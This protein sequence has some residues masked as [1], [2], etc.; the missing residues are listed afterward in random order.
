MSENATGYMLLDNLDPVEDPEEGLPTEGEGSEALEDCSYA[1]DVNNTVKEFAYSFR[2][3]RAVRKEIDHLKI[4]IEDIEEYGVSVDNYDSLVRAYPDFADEGGVLRSMCSPIR[5][6]VY[7]KEFISF[8]KKKLKFAEKDLTWWGM[9]QSR[10][11]YDYLDEAT[12]PPSTRMDPAELRDNLDS[13]EMKVM[14]KGESTNILDIPL[15]SFPEGEATLAS[16]VL[17][18]IRDLVT[19]DNPEMFINAMNHIYNTRNHLEGL[20]GI[21]LADEL[22][23]ATNT[24]RGILVL[25]TETYEEKVRASDDY[26]VLANIGQYLQQA[27]MGMIGNYLGAKIVN[28]EEE[29]H[30]VNVELE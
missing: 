7:K 24:L 11:V 5:T 10:I 21:E 19:V 20:N 8:L 14:F 13:P 3:L 28:V 25:D 2:G 18:N 23:S 16:F 1:D 30:F 6:N 26:P 29:K 4:L 15:K 22:I 12:L 27:A 17:A 9:N